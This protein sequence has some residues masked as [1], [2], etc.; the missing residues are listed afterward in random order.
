ML[1]EKRCGSLPPKEYLMK[2]VRIDAAGC[3]IWLGYINAFGYGSRKYRGR[4]FRAHRLVYLVLK[5]QIPSGLELDHLCRVRRCVN[6]DHLEPVTRQEHNRRGTG[7]SE[8]NRRKTHCP[9]G[10]AYDWAMK[11]GRINRQC[12]TCR[13]AQYNEMYA[14]RRDEIAKQRRDRRNRAAAVAGPLSKKKNGGAG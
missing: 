5:G 14:K 8:L 6:P 2:L 7:F 1:D 4:N 3:W 10:H 13:R 9:K 11:T 12:L